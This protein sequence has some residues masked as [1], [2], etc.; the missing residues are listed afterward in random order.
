MP[1][2]GELWAH[3]GEGR[4]KS[5]RRLLEVGLPAPAVRYRP[6]VQGKTEGPS[7]RERLRD[8]LVF[9]GHAARGGTSGGLVTS[10]LAFAATLLAAALAGFL[11]SALTL[12]AALLT[13]A[14]AGLVPLSLATLITRPISVFHGHSLTN[15]LRSIKNL[16]S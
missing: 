2:A 13:A 7:S 12:T 9:V 4:V 15:I 14:L 5:A 10:A 6:S 11:A 16:S 1:S 8:T 3:R